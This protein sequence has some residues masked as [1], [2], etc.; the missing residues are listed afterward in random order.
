MKQPYLVLGL[1]FSI[2]IL[3]K[4]SSTAVLNNNVLQSKPM[5]MDNNHS[6]IKMKKMFSNK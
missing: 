6:T 1:F 5:T 4:N 3:A 2:L